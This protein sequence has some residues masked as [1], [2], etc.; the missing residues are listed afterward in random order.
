LESL[1]VPL[2]SSVRPPVLWTVVTTSSPPVAE[3]FALSVSDGE[4]R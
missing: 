4:I 1:S 3:R 2:M